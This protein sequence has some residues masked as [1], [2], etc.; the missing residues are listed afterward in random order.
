MFA[1]FVFVTKKPSTAGICALPSR[2]RTLF[3]V[4]PIS[5]L[6]VPAPVILPPVKPVPATTLVTEPAPAGVW[7][8]HREPEEF[9]VKTSP[10]EGTP[11]RTVLPRIALTETLPAA[12][13]E[14]SPLTVTGAYMLPEVL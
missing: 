12:V 11:A 1:A 7:K 2:A 14:A 5:T 13:I 3:A 6:S 8:S 10:F 4:V 9:H